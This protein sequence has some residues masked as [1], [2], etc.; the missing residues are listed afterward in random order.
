M[1]NTASPKA[2]APP[3]RAQTQSKR[4]PARGKVQEWEPSGLD[5][6][7][8]YGDG[9]YMTTEQL[10]VYGAATLRSMI[11]ERYADA[12]RGTGSG[13]VLYV[14]RKPAIG[15]GRVCTICAACIFIYFNW[16]FFCHASATTLTLNSFC[17]VSS[18]GY[19]GPPLR[20]NLSIAV[21]YAECISYAGTAVEDISR[22][23][24]HERGAC[25]LPLGKRNLAV[26]HV[27]PA[28]AV[29]SA[30]AASVVPTTT[31]LGYT[32]SRPALSQIPS[33][34]SPLS[35]PEVSLTPSARSRCHGLSFWNAFL[36][37]V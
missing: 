17:S 32:P 14:F 12:I 8:E 29:P 4:G 37:V 3:H 28:L 15:W 22:Q 2:P 27:R 21:T 23:A 5:A 1:I 33:I 7:C 20:M 24:I 16:K 36:E 11:R 6:G 30:N 26:C 10:D 25:F 9:N 18:T 19:L 34:E 35:L 13:G 31:K